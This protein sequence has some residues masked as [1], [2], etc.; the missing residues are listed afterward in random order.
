M[1][2]LE[3]KQNFVELRAR[4]Y[5]YDMISEKLSIS[6]PTL[7]AWSKE[8]ENRRAIR[9]LRKEIV[10]EIQEQYDISKQ[11]RV[12]IFFDFLENARNEMSKRDLSK[13]P[14]DKLMSSIVKVSAALAIDESYIKGLTNNNPYAML[15]VDELRSLADR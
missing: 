4:G 6:R 12:H 1:K 14:T 9:G 2:T 8:V 13:V 7:F 5:S 11:V 15:S 10:S 3:D